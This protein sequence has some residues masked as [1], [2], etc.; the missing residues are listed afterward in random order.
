MLYK[1]LFAFGYHLAAQ[2]DGDD[3][4]TRRY[5]HPLVAQAQGDVL[6]IGA[7][8]G[9]N[10]PYFSPGVRLTT[11]EPNPF[12][13]NYLREATADAAVHVQDVVNDGAEQMPFPDDRFDTVLSVHVLCSVSNLSQALS[14]INRVL[15]PGGRFLFLEHVQAH[16]EG[17]L[18]R[19]QRIINPAWKL[20]GDGC[21]L[22]RDTASAIRAA[23]FADHHIEE[24]EIGSLGLVKPHIR[25]W[26]SAGE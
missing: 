13:V 7:G 17:S 24:L 11:L 4:F 6:E 12:M 26:A 23:G 8:P 5:R 15:R 10:L 22:T 25:G 19:S 3:E 14:E 16:Q 21:H 1:R 9:T 18:R 2:G 20:I